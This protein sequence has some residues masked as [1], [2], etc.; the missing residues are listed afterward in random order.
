M[1]NNKDENEIDYLE[2]CNECNGYFEK[3]EMKELD[4]KF[5]CRDCSCRCIEC[6][7]LIDEDNA[8]KNSFC[9]KDCYN[10]YF[11]DLYEEDFKERD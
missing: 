5:Y 9:G 10:T 6:N 2:F 3:S 8:Y 7:D 4:S 1:E 11:Y